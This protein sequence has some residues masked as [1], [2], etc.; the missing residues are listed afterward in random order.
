MYKHGGKG[1]RLYN[2]WKLIRKR[3][4]NPH[5]PKWRR[6]GA[7]GIFCDKE[8]DDFDKFRTWA[9]L[10]GYK[11]DLTIDRIDNNGP[12]A[13][14]NCQWLSKSEHQKKSHIDVPQSSSWRIRDTLGRFTKEGN[15]RPSYPWD[16]PLSELPNGH[17]KNQERKIRFAQ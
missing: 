17:I 9:V 15:S 8:W 6:Y 3:C 13:T 16:L 5:N 10:N 11:D 14:W 1:T 12:Y 7:R 2:I 4:N